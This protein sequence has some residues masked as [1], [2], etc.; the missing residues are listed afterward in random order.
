[1]T[2]KK[3]RQHFSRHK[4]DGYVLLTLLLAAA[5]MMIFA[6]AIMPS[7]T[8]QIKRDREEEMIHRGV[9]Y[10]RAIRL[11]YRRLGRYPM[12]LEDLESTNNMRFLRKRYKDPVV[13]RDFK[14]LH[15]GEVQL[16][17]QGGITAG[18]SPMIPPGGDAN[19]AP[20]PGGALNNNGGSGEAASFARTNG[21]GA[22]PISTQNSPAES[23][24]ISGNDSSLSSS[25]DPQPNQP[26]SSGSS[27][28]PGNIVSGQTFGGPIVGVVSTS[29]TA[30]FRE[31]DRKQKYNEWNFVFDPEVG[32]ALPV[33]PN[34]RPLFFSAQPLTPNGAAGPPGNMP[35]K[36]S[37]TPAN[38]PSSGGVPPTAVSSSNE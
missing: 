8:S 27:A 18:I 4:Q 30:G 14:L 6:G 13:G 23:N 3:P 28:Y 16:S 34:Q 22:S 31:F 19:G 24:P 21:F 26:G 35:S 10:S 36:E 25:P 33:G 32:N 17:A 12:R 7:I 15:F 2:L 38:M 29:K 20:S 37:Q 11:Y 1:M 5:T 9:Q